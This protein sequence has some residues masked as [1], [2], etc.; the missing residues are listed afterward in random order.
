[1][2]HS[3]SREVAMFEFTLQKTV[4]QKRLEKSWKLIAKCCSQATMVEK[5]SRT[6]QAEGVGG[7]IERC[8]GATLV[9]RG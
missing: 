9:T 4:R 8:S 5:V 3:F 1:M 2:L 7:S 6:I